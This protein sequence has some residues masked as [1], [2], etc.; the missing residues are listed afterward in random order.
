MLGTNWMKI[1]AEERAG[2]RGQAA[3][4]QAH[5][6]EDRQ[7]DREAVGRDEGDHHRTER[8][9]HAGER[10]RHAEGERLEHRQVDAHRGGRDRMVANGDQRAP[11]AA[12]QQVPRQHE[13]H[14]GH[15]Q[16]EEVEPAVGVE[17]LIEEAERERRLGLDQHDALHAAGVVLQVLVLQQLRHRQRE[18]QRGHAPDSGHPAATPESPSGSRSTKHTTPAS[19]SVAQ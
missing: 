11:D 9:G 13:H 15:R 6:Q 16:R 14:D 18:R 8:A 5:Q 7:R 2:D 19:G 17:R 3:D 1:G 10:R 4:H 12:A